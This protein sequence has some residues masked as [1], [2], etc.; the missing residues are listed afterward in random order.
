MAEPSTLPAVRPVEEVAPTPT[1]APLAVVERWTEE[2]RAFVRKHFCGGAPEHVADLFLR[3]CERKGLSPEDKQVYL[4]ARGGEHSIETGIDGYRALAARTGAYAGSDPPVYEGSGT[5]ANQRRH[6]HKATVTVYRIVQGQRCPFTASVL[7]EEFTTGKNKWLTMPAHMLGKVAESHALR[8]AFPVELSGIYTDAEMEQ[9]E[10]VV[11]GRDVPAAAAV[12]AA[13]T[14]D[15]LSWNG[16]WAW[17]RSLGYRRREDVEAV[18]GEWNGDG[19]AEI[20]ARLERARAETSATEAPGQPAAPANGQSAADQRR[21]A[22]AALHAFVGDRCGGD[23]HRGVK[24]LQFHLYDGDDSSLADEAA[25]P[26]ERLRDFYRQLRSLH[27]ADLVSIATAEDDDAAPIEVGGQLVD[28]ETGEILG[29]ADADAPASRAE[30]LEQL[31]H[32][33]RSC[34]SADDWTALT[35]EVGTDAAEWTV[36]AEEAHATG[37]LNLLRAACRRANANTPEMEGIFNQR[38]KAVRRMAEATTP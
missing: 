3:A 24:L 20:K 4:I 32:L 21:A 35:Q 38:A 25:W 1:T 13:Q 6:P 29:P 33:A 26:I 23:P 15:P 14:G 16:F 2:R 22:L 31:R 10:I 19:P 28:P 8:K 9:A 5:L 34:Q 27:P 36:L 18:T 7:W 11:H 12:P 30:E 37:T 17:A